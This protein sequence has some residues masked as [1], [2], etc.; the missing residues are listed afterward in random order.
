MPVG[1]EEEAYASKEDTAGKNRQIH[2]RLTKARVTPRL[3]SL[4]LDGASDSWLYRLNCVPLTQNGDLFG[5]TL[6]RCN[7]YN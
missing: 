6:G 1:G 5:N 2:T 7:Y 3:T 4:Q